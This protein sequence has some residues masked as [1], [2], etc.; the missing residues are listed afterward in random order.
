MTGIII[1]EHDT[2]PKNGLLWASE[3]NM[4]RKDC[5]GPCG[6]ADT[7]LAELFQRSD[8]LVQT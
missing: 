6:S 1:Q 2:C 8:S 3:N 5:A 7:Y 4:G